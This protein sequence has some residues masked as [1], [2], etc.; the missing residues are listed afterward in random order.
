MK[1]AGF[2]GGKIEP[3]LSS[4]AH[5]PRDAAM[6]ILPLL[7]SVSDHVPKDGHARTRVRVDRFFNRFLYRTCPVVGFQKLEVTGCDGLN[8]QKTLPENNDRNRRLFVV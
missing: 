5:S 7:S 2:A 1:V 8:F 6:H 3:G 4:F